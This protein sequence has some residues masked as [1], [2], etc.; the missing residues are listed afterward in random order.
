[1][2]HLGL[3]VALSLAWLLGGLCALLAQPTIVI[4]G[5]P[6][7]T[8]EHGPCWDNTNRFVDCGNGTVTDTT[9]GLVWLQRANCTELP[10]TGGT[11][12]DDWPTAVEAAA[13]LE[14][15]LCGLTDGSE[16]GDWRLPTA[17]EW[18]ATLVW[19]R[20][21]LACT[22]ASAPTWTNDAG[23]ACI[24]SPVTSFIGVTAT[25]YWSSSIDAVFTGFA[26]VGNLTT[27]LSTGQAAKFVNAGIWPVRGFCTDYDGCPN[28]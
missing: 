26:D 10:G 7:L 14:D 22:G 18:E 13:A 9:T 3:T 28:W 17:D 24:T 25:N 6:A 8:K 12:S 20:D 11:N 23:T 21:G 27:G 2:K 19:A 16:P 5:H 15:G 1:M 4:H